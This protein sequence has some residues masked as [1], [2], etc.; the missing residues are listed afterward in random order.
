MIESREQ[1]IHFLQGKVNE[2]CVE[3]PEKFT[4]PNTTYSWL[5]ASSEPT[6]NVLITFGPA[7]KV[8][9]HWLHVLAQVMEK[10]EGEGWGLLRF[11]G[12]DALPTAIETP[13]TPYAVYWIARGGLKLF[14]MYFTFRTARVALVRCVEDLSDRLPM[15]EEDIIRYWDAVYPVVQK[16]KKTYEQIIKDGNI[17]MA[18]I[19]EALMKPMEDRDDL[20]FAD[21][22]TFFQRLEDRGHN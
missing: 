11:M 15:A 21:K 9:I 19:V 3:I 2:V 18:P 4:Q 1:L 14:G 12:E 5:T 7:P 22:D 17:R 13:E 20:R 8:S 6:E 16:D 10:K